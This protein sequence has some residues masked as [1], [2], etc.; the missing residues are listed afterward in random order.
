M[1]GCGKMGGALLGNWVRSGANF[2]IV[3]PALEVE[4]PR[5][6]L[7]RDTGDL[8]SRKFDVIIIGIKPQLIERVMPAYSGM[9]NDDGYVLSIAAG[10]SIAKI[11]SL[12][13]DAPVVRVMPNLP[14]AVGQGVSALCASDDAKD[15]HLAH[16]QELM[17]LTGTAITVDDE[18]QIDR[19]TG[20]AGSGP[21]YIFEFAHAFVEAAMELG[22]DEE[23]ARSMV[24]G[25]MA[26]A[27]EMARTSDESLETLRNSV[28]SKGGTTAAGLEAF[29]GDETISNRLKSTVTAAYERAL[30]LK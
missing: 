30:E 19:F 22:F 3:D 18:D 5:T 8:A 10:C 24:L 13:E 4:P 1:V 28:T 17:A 2:T 14:A 7:V 26:G 20:I 27:I 25:T 6:T 23:A 9:L 12:T 16:A 29:N 11:K 21:G 15:D